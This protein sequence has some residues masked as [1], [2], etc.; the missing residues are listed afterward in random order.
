VYKYKRQFKYLA[1]F[2]ATRQGFNQNQK[3]LLTGESPETLNRVNRAVCFCI[4][5]FNLGSSYDSKP[6][7]VCHG[8]WGLATSNR[9]LQDL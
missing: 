5:F 9:K 1:H 6:Q 2:E 3:A 8:N 4:Y 7:S